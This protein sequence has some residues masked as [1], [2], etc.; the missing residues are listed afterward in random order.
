MSRS[1]LV[2]PI[3]LHTLDSILHP[4]VG[5]DSTVDNAE[6]PVTQDGLDPEH[7]VIDGLS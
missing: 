3:L 5:V 6:G 7:T 4:C 1:R 2:V